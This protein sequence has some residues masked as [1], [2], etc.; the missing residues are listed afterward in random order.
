MRAVKNCTDSAEN[1]RWEGSVKKVP[2]VR[3]H[4]G[5]QGSTQMGNKQYAEMEIQ[6]TRQRKMIRQVDE[7]QTQLKLEEMGAALLAI[8]CGTCHSRKGQRLTETA[9]RKHIE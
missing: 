6:A 1:K 2:N 7:G 8:Q 4:W 3:P 9:F 5:P